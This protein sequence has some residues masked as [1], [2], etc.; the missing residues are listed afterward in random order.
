MVNFTGTPILRRLSYLCSIFALAGWKPEVK[1]DSKK[2]SRE[3][4]DFMLELMESHPEAL[5]SE[6]DFQNMMHVYP[7]RF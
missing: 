5:Q 6:L 2:R 3:R 1:K 7:S 4:R